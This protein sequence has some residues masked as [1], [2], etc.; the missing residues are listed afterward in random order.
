MPPINAHEQMYRGP[1]DS[2]LAEV[3][4]I[5]KEMEENEKLKADDSINKERKLLLEGK[6]ESLRQLEMEKLKGSEYSI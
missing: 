2:I 1:A 6:I 3:M 4:D 5:R